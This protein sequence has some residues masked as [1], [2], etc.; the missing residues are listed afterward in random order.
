MA[1]DLNNVSDISYGTT[2]RL[3]VIF[4]GNIAV[5]KT[6]IIK[7]LLGQKVMEEYEASVGIDFFSLSKKYK[8]KVIKIQMWDTAG[9]EKY[10]S[11]I[12]NYVRGSSIVFLVYDI[13]ERSSFDAVPNWIKFIKDYEHTTIILLANKSDLKDKRTVTTEEGENYAK[14]N[15]LDFHEIS[16]KNDNLQP[17][18]YSSIAGLLQSIASERATK[19]EIVND[20]MAENEDEAGQGAKTTQGE[21]GFQR[22]AK[23]VINTGDDMPDSLNTPAPPKKKKGKKCIGCPESGCSRCRCSMRHSGITTTTGPA[24]TKAM[25]LLLYL[26]PTIF[27]FPVASSHVDSS[28]FFTY[29]VHSSARENCAVRP[30]SVRI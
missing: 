18:L 8:G 14:D 17:I 3:K 19:E 1:D 26:V 24:A 7:N 6:S 16:A 2:T 13:A 20:L 11:L 15:N 10:K 22:E 23:A 29:S 27:H 21:Q 25:L 12:P 9:Q 28:S 4:I 30:S 5:G